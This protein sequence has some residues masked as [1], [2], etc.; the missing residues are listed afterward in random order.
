MQQG[1]HT[2]PTSGTTC[3]VFYWACQ[4]ANFNVLGMVDSEGVLKERYEYTPYG[5]RTV[6]FSPGSNDGG[7][8]APT[9][10]SRR[11]TGG[12][13]TQPYGLCEFGHQ[14]LMHDQEFRFIN[15]RNRT[16]FPGWARFDRR[17]SEGYIDGVS[18][19]EY[20]QSNPVRFVD[21]KGEDAAD[22]GTNFGVPI[23]RPCGRITV[24]G[25]PGGVT[26][27]MVNLRKA[28]VC[29]PDSKIMPTVLATANATLG[30]SLPIVRDIGCGAGQTCKVC[31]S[32]TFGP[33]M[34][35]PTPPPPPSTF[36]WSLTG[37]T[38]PR[39]TWSTPLGPCTVNAT[40]TVP[41][42]LTVGIGSCQS[43]AG[44]A[45]GAGN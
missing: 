13:I 45:P 12:G 29:P 1:I 4:D 33:F 7:C 19:Y 35:T 22:L 42:T 18:L 21:P 17:D 30:A 23:P 24:S 3:D 38:G 44:P 27:A 39:R 20:E 9:Y 37:N 15:N 32:A 31:Q 25:P 11:V 26:A 10:A 43:A 28:G 14:G 2:D 36:Y 6:L 40:V 41:I 5:Q 8:Y 16:P 34:Y